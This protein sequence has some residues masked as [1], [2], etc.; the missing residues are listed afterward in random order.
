[1]TRD[2]AVLILKYMPSGPPSEECCAE[3][4]P[5]LWTIYCMAKN[6]SPASQGSPWTEFDVATSCAIMLRKHLND[7]F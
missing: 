7:L 5:D 6:R 2:M 3:V 4:N 1:M